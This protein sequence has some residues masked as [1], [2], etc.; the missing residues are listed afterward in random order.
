MLSSAGRHPRASWLLSGAAAFS[1]ALAAPTQIQLRAGNPGAGYISADIHCLR[2][3]ATPQWAA[4][5]FAVSR[6]ADWRCAFRAALMPDE[7]KT[8]FLEWPR[9][10]W[11]SRFFDNHFSDEIEFVSP[12]GLAQLGVPIQSSP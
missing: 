9:K 2:A 5:H 4:A 6:R 1:G 8:A 11:V 3:F 10:N 12:G 7:K